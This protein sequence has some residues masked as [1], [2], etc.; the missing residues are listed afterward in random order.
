M[1]Q[2]QMPQFVGGL[3]AIDCFFATY[4]RWLRGKKG[5]FCKK[6]TKI[7]NNERRVY[8]RGT[9]IDER[10]APIPG[11]PCLTGLLVIANSPR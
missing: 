9:Y 3:T 7:R 5:N 8:F 10:D 6:M 4:T 2:I 11:V 1:I